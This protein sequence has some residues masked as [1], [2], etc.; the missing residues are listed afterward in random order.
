VENPLKLNS[1]K[2]WDSKVPAK[3][4]AL[5]SAAPRAYDTR[6]VDLKAIQQGCFNGTPKDRTTKHDAA[7][8]TADN[9]G[10]AFG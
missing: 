10:I 8:K 2:N 5:K 7:W 3:M 6:R 9:A 1:K 4:H